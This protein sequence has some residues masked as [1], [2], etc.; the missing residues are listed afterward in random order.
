MK[1]SK[2]MFVFGLLFI[3]SILG[4]SGNS[5]TSENAVALTPEDEFRCT[6]RS[7]DGSVVGRCYFCDC[8][9]FFD[10]WCSCIE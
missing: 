3:A 9:A 7:S 6:V 5:R 4:A 10:M 8:D 2:K 1:R